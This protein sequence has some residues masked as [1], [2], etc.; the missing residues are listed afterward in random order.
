MSHLL[1]LPIAHAVELAAC[2]E[3]RELQVLLDRLIRDALEHLATEGAMLR[4]AEARH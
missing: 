1:S 3:P 4:A 2:S